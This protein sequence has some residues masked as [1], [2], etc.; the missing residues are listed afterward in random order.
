MYTL[1]GE[2][3]SSTPCLLQWI[4]QSEYG[5]YDIY[6]DPYAV[7][8]ICLPLAFAY[9]IPSAIGKR[10]SHCPHDRH[11]TTA[12][13]HFHLLIEN[14]LQL[15]W[16]ESAGVQKHTHQTGAGENLMLTIEW[17]AQLSIVCLPDLTLA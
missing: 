16:Q 12:T 1:T 6:V 5:A 3:D 10:F 9:G 7:A 14:R 4:W 17:H 13:R 15:V 8:C 11:I 2:F